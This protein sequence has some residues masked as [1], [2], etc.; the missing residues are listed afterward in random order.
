VLA[1]LVLYLAIAPK[2]NAAYSAYGA[3]R[4]LVE[5]GGSLEVPLELRN[6]PTRL[7][8]ELGYGK[9]YQYDHDAATGIA[10]GQRGFPAELGE[11]VLYAPTERGLE[12]K[13]RE[14]LEWIRARRREALGGA[15]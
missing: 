3:A 13:I 8:K 6:A 15:P 5:A 14:R 10:F 9:G 7:M 11:Q 4:R 1:Q 12:A 2:S